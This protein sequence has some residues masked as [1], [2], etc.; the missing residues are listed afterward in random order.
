[1]PQNIKNLHSLTAEIV[2]MCK[3]YFC[4]GV[5]ARPAAFAKGYTTWATSCRWTP[6]T[7]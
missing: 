5:Y 6:K 3:F 2:G 4:E 1:M 7:K